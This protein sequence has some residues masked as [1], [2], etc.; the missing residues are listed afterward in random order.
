MSPPTQGGKEVTV[1][2]VLTKIHGVPSTAFMFQGHGYPIRQFRDLKDGA[3]DG[4]RS[5]QSAAKTI[6]KRIRKAEASHLFAK[7]KQINTFTTSFLNTEYCVQ[8]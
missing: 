8:T 5:S 2:L 4:T 6:H 3:C 7:S 1:R